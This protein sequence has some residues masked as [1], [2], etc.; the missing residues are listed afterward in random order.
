MPIIALPNSNEYT[1]SATASNSRLR[2]HANVILSDDVLEV[3][4]SASV[5]GGYEQAHPLMANK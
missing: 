1:R 5:V 3:V 4:M 2:K